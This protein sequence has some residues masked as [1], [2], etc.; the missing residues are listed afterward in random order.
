MKVQ[1]DLTDKGGKA[2][3]SLELN[4]NSGEVRESP[5]FLIIDKSLQ[6]YVENGD[7]PHAHSILRYE[8][9]VKVIL[10]LQPIRSILDVACGSGYGSYLLA[11][12]MPAGHVTGVDYDPRAIDFAQKNYKLPNLEYK[13]GDI[14]RWEETIGSAVFD[15]ILFFD[16]IEHLLHREIAMENIVTHLNPEG[17]LFLSTP[18]AQPDLVLRPEWERHK[19]EYNVASLYDFLKRY[20]VNVIRPETPHFPH[21]EIFDCIKG[22]KIPY[23]LRLNP[24]ICQVPIQIGNPY[25]GNKQSLS[26]SQRNSSNTPI[27]ERTMHKAFKTWDREE[28]SLSA[29]EKRIHDDISLDKLGARAER[30]LDTI[31]YLF[32]WS[33]PNK[34]AAILEVGSGVGYILEAALKRF[35]PSHIIGLDVAPSMIEKAKKRFERDG[36]DDSRIEFLLYDGVTIPIPDDSLDFIYSVACIQ[37]IPKPYAYNLFFEMLRILKPSGFAAFQL[38][39]FSYLPTHVEREPFKY[40]VNR[41]IR[42]EEGHWHHFYSFDEVFYILSSG[43]GAKYIDIY[44]TDFELYACFGKDRERTFFNESLPGLTHK[45]A[46]RK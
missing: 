7:I 20:F 39:S 22:T 10:D 23:I 42:N 15:C 17:S 31:A 12:N 3:S 11:K 24:V 34:D 26:K 14:T 21:L 13:L 27:T 2:D 29:T 18:N 28:E 30:Y 37:H 45:A 41:Q 8:W 38:L 43:I 32:P 25:L 16:T 6:Y 5:E 4:S 46:R 33:L 1:K 9:A 44:D 40:E 35:G 19:I 36:V